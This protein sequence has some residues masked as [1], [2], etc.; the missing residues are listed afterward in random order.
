MSKREKGVNNGSKKMKRKLEKETR[1]LKEKL[2]V[3][4]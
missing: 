3:K 2:I 1:K 4:E